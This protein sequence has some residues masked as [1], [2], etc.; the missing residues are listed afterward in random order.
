MNVIN[1]KDYNKSLGKLIC[2]EN[3][4]VY[5]VNHVD[6]SINIPLDMLLYNKDRILS[7]NETYYIY[8]LGGRKAKKACTMLELYG[9]KT[10]LV[11][12]N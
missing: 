6:G 3:S 11:L 9:Y 5:K 12:L 4:D 10:V 1:I 2:V 8:C 7:K